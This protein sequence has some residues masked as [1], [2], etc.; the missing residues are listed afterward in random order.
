M[1]YKIILLIVCVSC[2][3]SCKQA[4]ITPENKMTNSAEVVPV[5]DLKVLKKTGK[6]LPQKVSFIATI[7]YMD[8]E[9]GFYGLTTNDGKH[10]LPMNLA[11]EF[12]H[13]GTV[14]KVQ[15]HEVKGMMTIQQ[16]GSQF[17]ITSIEVI[18]Q[19]VSSKK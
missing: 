10:W 13:D 15:G 14:V 2:L 1:Y 4:L 6:D 11:K 3:L 5:R 12:Q 19:G 8:F 9:G 16:W 18:K 7:K 17:S